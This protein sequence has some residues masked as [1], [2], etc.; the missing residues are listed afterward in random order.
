MSDELKALSD[1]MDKIVNAPSQSVA[2]RVAFA[3]RPR[4]WHETHGNLYA[5]AHW[6]TEHGLFT[7]AEDVLDYLEKPWHWDDEWAAFVEGGL[8]PGIGPEREEWDD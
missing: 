5:L 2:R 1:A 6:L 3:K 7:T 4:A 8:P